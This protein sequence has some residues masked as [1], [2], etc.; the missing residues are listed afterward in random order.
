ML[1]PEGLDILDG[2]RDL[3]GK[4]RLQIWGLS[5]RLNSGNWG[6]KSISLENKDIFVI[7]R[8]LAGCEAV[9]R[10][11]CCRRQVC[12]TFRKRA[13]IPK[14]QKSVQIR[15]WR[16]D[17]HFPLAIPS[18]NDGVVDFFPQQTYVCNLKKDMYC[19]ALIF[20]DVRY[21][22]YSN[23]G[24][25]PLDISPQKRQKLFEKARRILIYWLPSKNT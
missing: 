5:A 16:I 1:F 17:C 14:M 10:L 20:F 24:R 22:T 23:G 6:G 7:L 15:K 13:I 9:I 3:L 25:W 21:I 18:G 12:D 4:D 2:C 8:L 19:F 11:T